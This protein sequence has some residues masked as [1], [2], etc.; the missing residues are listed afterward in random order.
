VR[1]IVPP[2]GSSQRRAWMRG[3][4][5]VPS[6]LATTCM[7]AR[8]LCPLRG[9]SQRRARM[10][11][12]CAPCGAPRNDVLGCAGIASSRPGREPGQSLLATTCEVAL[13]VVALRKGRRSPACESSK[14]P[15]VPPP[16]HTIING[17]ARAFGGGGPQGRRGLGRSDLFHTQSV[18]ASPVL[19]GEAI[20]TT[21]R[22]SL[23]A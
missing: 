21:R 7:D 13:L 18:V 9:S 6:V 5:F 16:V 3:D 12:D 17:L 4:C 20:S 1:H 10:H 22:M 14:L 2:A 8:R 15:R 11:G 19:W 23:R